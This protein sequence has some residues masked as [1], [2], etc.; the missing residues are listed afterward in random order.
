MA[1]A[2]GY[3]NIVYR[4]NGDHD[5]SITV[6]VEIELTGREAARYQSYASDEMG[7]L[8][9]DDVYWLA[10]RFSMARSGDQE[11]PGEFKVA[12]EFL[13]F[14]DKRGLVLRMTRNE[15][16]A[17]ALRRS[18]EM[19]GRRAKYRAA[20]YPLSEDGFVDFLKSRPTKPT[21]LSLAQLQF[22]GL[23]T[24]VFQR[25]GRSRVFQLSPQQCRLTGVSTPNAYL[26]RYGSNLPPVADYM[27]RNSPESWERVQAAM[28][29]VEPRLQSIDV[30]YTDDRRLALH[31]LKDGLERP[32]NSSEVSDGTIQVLALFVALFDERTPFLAVEEPEN[33]LHPWILR[34]F[35]DLCRHQDKQILLTTHSPVLIDY[36]PP[37][38]LRLVWQREGRTL[39]A[40]VPELSP[41]LLE[42][43]KAGEL[44]TF[45]AYDSGL[46]SEY[47]PER[48]LPADSNG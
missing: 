41:E 2:G 28:R 29:S 14:R 22:G 8:P 23:I 32:W 40:R 42:M 39:V 10:L 31:F 12:S 48:F 17:V 19:Q 5:K 15:A 1:R 34:Q 37:S 18:R 9:E 33:S 26:D 3:D 20:L 25:F 7:A 30:T 13:S 43:W 44:R 27:R 47:L 16:G 46:L 36:V 6:G 38:V 4:R 35:V 24:E 45:E 21:M 11:S